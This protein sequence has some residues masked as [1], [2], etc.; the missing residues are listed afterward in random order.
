MK[1]PKV[2]V[3]LP[4]YNVAP[5]LPKCI[6]YLTNQTLKDIEIIFVDDCSPDNSA[7]II[8]TYNDPRIKL[9]RH[10]KNKYTAEARNSGI[11]A[12]K[13]EYLSFMDPDD[14]PALDFLEKLY[15]LAKKEDADIAKGTMT[16]MPMNKLWSR[17]NKIKENKFNF[18]FM[19][20]SA[21]YR[22]KMI[23]DNNIHFSIDVI[24]GQFPMVYYANKI[25]TC[26]DATYYYLKRL[27]SC[28]NQTFT[29]EKWEKLNIAGAKFVLD[30]MNTHEMQID[31]YCL[32]ARTLVLNLYQYGYNKMLYEDKEKYK[33]LLL[34]YLDDFW[35]NVKYKDNKKLATTYQNVRL[36]YA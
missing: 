35:L 24:C 34:K 22:R 7:D 18:H 6:E 26:E 4:V 28:I 23:I 10:K 29:K 27:G 36:K 32:I 12:A 17:N 16:F 15:T 21:I 25:V 1:S 30:F 13:G 5:Y 14:W 31:D 9:I 11:K 20:Q 8:K 19:H 33:V 3:I 2:S